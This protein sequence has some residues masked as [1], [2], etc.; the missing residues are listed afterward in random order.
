ARAAGLGEER[1]AV[2]FHLGFAQ[3]AAPRRLIPFALPLLY[4]AARYALADHSLALTQGAL[5]SGDL[6]AAAAHYRAS[7]HTSDLWYSRAL[8]AAAQKSPYVRFRLQALQQSADA[9]RRATRTAEAP[10][11]AW[12]KLAAIQ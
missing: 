11:N 7:G 6:P 8:L 3:I 9:A 2:G 5:Q 1:V 10:F 12:Y 4:F